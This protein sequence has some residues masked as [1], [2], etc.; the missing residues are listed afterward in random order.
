MR[1]QNKTKLAVLARVTA[2]T[3]LWIQAGVLA[4]QSAPQITSPANGAIVPSGSTL[5]VTVNAPPFAFQSVLI[6]GKPFGFSDPVTAPPFQFQ[7]PIPADSASGPYTIEAMGIVAPGKWMV[8]DSVTID[9]ERPDSP[10]SLSTVF[11]SLSFHRKGD[12]IRLLLEGVFADGTSVDLTHSKF[13]TYSSTIPSVATVDADGVVTAVGV[14]Y[15]EITIIHGSLNTSVGVFVA[16]PVSISP[17]HVV[18]YASG[19]QQLFVQVENGSREA[20]VTWSL[21]PGDPGT[22]DGTGLYT[23]P[24]PINALQIVT[25]TATDTTNT[26]A[27][28]SAK[29]WLY[30]P[31]T[32]SVTP[33]AISLGPS[34]TTQITASVTNP[35]N[36]LVV[37]SAEPDGVGA[38][39]PYSGDYTAP[40]SIASPQMVTVTAT[41]MTDPPLTAT[42]IISL[43]P[44]TDVISTPNIPAGPASGA[45]GTLYQFTA[46]GSVDSLGSP[47]QYSFNW[48]DGL[49]SGWTPS[50]A[51]S[52]FHSW[53][54]PGTYMVQAIA[55]STL[56]P[57]VVSTASN[58]LAVVIA[59]ESIAAPATPAGPASVLTGTSYSYSTGGAV[60]NLG[61]AVQFKLF[62]GDGSNSPWLPVGTTSSSHTWMG[63]GTYAVTAQ[64]RCAT[65]TQVMSP[66]SVG[67]PVTVANGE[68]VSV[69]AAPLGPASGVV[70]T[71]YTYSTGGATSSS[72]DPVVYL[73]DWGDGTTSGWL[74]AGRTTAQHAW[75]SAGA[76]T[77]TVIA[78]DQY[79]LLVQSGASAG[80]A[81]QVQ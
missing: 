81:V 19:T 75:K 50:G 72:G 73:F 54:V 34:G 37:W 49:F 1:S 23:A 20:S 64:A 11:Q 55:R 14:G 26:T 25:V 62:W 51:T 78:A 67:M 3:A 5:A 80:L 43:N 7:V 52:S 70:G 24:S 13:T 4:A 42:A 44:S 16:P 36:A 10:Q 71:T 63:A 46:S 74:T 57:N 33:T 77:V 15:G 21:A 58:P 18:V 6:V 29:I 35:P 79:Y 32:L 28:A 9:I 47:V 31:P 65:D 39:D 2:F 38:I 76:Y 69:P 27:K 53:A 66:L 56:A 12:N 48:G 60:S 17:D 22:I 8:S 40:D 45:T 68:T 59:G 61:H 30:P 41:S